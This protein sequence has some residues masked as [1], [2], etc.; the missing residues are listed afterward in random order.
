[1]RKILLLSLSLMISSAVY[2]AVP[3]PTATSREFRSPARFVEIED[4]SP[5][6]IKA[7][8]SSDV[9]G[10]MFIADP[11]NAL[12]DGAEYLGD[13]LSAASDEYIAS[14]YDDIASVF[15][16][17]GNFPTVG[18]TDAETAYFVREYFSEGGGYENVGDADRAIAASKILS[19]DPHFFRNG[20]LGSDLQLNLSVYKGKIRDGFAWDWAASISFKGAEDLLYQ[21]YYPYTDRYY[22]NDISFT[23]GSD[24]GY[25]WYVDDGLSLG[26]SASPRIFCDTYFMN[27]AYVSGRID[28]SFLSVF[29]ANRYNI[30]FSIGLNVGMMYR[31][32]DELA[33]IVDLR[34]VPTMRTYWYFTADDFVNGFRFHHDSNLYLTPPDIAISVLFD[35]GPLHLGVELGDALSQAVWANTVE[36]YEYDIFSIPKIRVGYDISSSLT[37]SAKLEYRRLMIGLDWNDFVIELS[38]RLDR[39]NAGVQIRYS[40]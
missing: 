4:S 40:F 15:D 20:L 16:F 32:N 26:V 21:Y 8:F 25:A 34:D 2:A 33:F 9:D 38:T 10:L 14:H 18:H 13:Y 17:D 31:L 6:G 24:I 36:G 11:V 28:D 30:G 22:G 23:F 35:K 1:M 19:S 3:V 12:K 27:G 29:A 37:L 5:F 39:L 7:G